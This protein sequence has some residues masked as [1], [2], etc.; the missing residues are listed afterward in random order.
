MFKKLIIRKAIVNLFASIY[1]RKT[2]AKE[3]SEKSREV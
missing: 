3:A 2:I 1:H